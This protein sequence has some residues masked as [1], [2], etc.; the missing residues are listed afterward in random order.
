MTQKLFIV[1]YYGKWP[2]YFREWLYTAQRMQ[3]AGY[4]FLLVTD[5]EIDYQLPVN[6][7][8]LKMELKTIK[9]RISSLVGFECSLNHPYKLC[10]YKPAYGLI[11]E[12]ELK[13][14]DFWG[15]CDLDILW[16]DYSRF[17]PEELFQKY[18]KIQ[19]LGHSVLYRNVPEINRAFML[20]GG[21]FSFTEVF[22]SDCFFSFD[23]H[24]GMCGIAINNGLNH[25]E[26]Y[27]QADL[28][29][30]FERPVISRANNYPYQIIYWDDGKI[31]RAYIDK[32]ELKYDSFSYL[33]FQ[34]KAPLGLPDWNK[35]GYK[36]K[37]ILFNARQLIDI[38]DI[39]IDRDFV[40]RNSDYKG[41]AY[42]IGEIIKS[43]YN[44]ILWFTKQGKEQRK[45]S[46]RIRKATNSVISIYKGSYNMVK[47]ER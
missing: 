47:S 20:Y 34:K 42:E 23:E 37:R 32:E 13:E 21:E 30:A 46:I 2:P 38:S 29:A 24:P 8:V 17:V 18:D 33:H 9:E 19:F 1:C 7:N 26:S 6:V 36:P 41:K 25:W 28:S 35:K 3:E 14:F 11:F 44:K 39:D 40:I 16:G 15:H 4:S 12:E 5:L 27:N 22:R 45:V 43:K 31:M 10:D